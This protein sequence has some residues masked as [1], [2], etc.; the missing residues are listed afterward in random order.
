MK[1]L[2]ILLTMILFV[3]VAFSETSE[4]KKIQQ[5]IIKK[6]ANGKASEN[7]VTR[8]SKEEQKK[9]CNY[10]REIP[11]LQK[12]DLLQLEM[13]EDLPS[14]FDWRDVSGV[15]WTTPVKDQYPA[16]SCWAFSAV[17][18]LESW[19]KIE[20]SMPDSAIDLSEQFLVA[21]NP[22]ANANDG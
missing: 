1:K 11:K 7:W 21:C 15:N 22:D 13:V 8:L 4:L 17:G 16:G 3:T 18:Q 9:L 20:N 19:W 10:K 5:A 14:E 12:G 2:L 6:G